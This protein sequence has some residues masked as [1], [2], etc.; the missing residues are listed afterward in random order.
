MNDL[1]VCFDEIKTCIDNKNYE[2][3]DELLTLYRKRNSVY[4]DFVAILDG[5]IGAYFGDRKRQWKAIQKGLE[6]N[7]QN[8]E[9]YVML[10]NYYL[11][12]NLHQAY[13]CYENAFFYC[14]DQEDKMQIFALMQ[15]LADEYGI[16]V[17]KTAIVILSYNLL[18]YTKQ[19]IESI[20]KSTLES[21]REIIII[22]NAS[23]DGSVE[24]L[25]TQKDIKLVLNTENK[26]FPAGCNQGIKEAD[27]DSDIFL[28]NNDTILTPNALFWL[29]MGLYENEN[30]GATG[31]VS[32]YVAN[33]QQ[34]MKEWEN[35]Q[36][37]LDF[38]DKNN[39]PLKYPYEEKLFLIGFAY[40]IKRSVLN[41]VGLLDEIFSPGN[42]EDVDY[43]LRVLQAGY[44]NVLCRNSFILHFG[45]KSFGKL[46]KGYAE[47]LN[48][49]QALLNKKWEM[50]MQY[51]MFPRMELVNLI[52]EE[53]EKRM[54]IL[55]IGCGCGAIMAKVKSQYPLSEIKGIEIVSKAAQLASAIGEVTCGDVEQ[56]DFSY[57][58]SYFDYCIM[59]DV[60]EHLREPQKVLIRLQKHMKKGGKII[61]SMPNMKH[62]SVMLP[63]L[64]QDAF[65]Y[66]N[67][68]IL[69]KT[70][71]KMYTN[72]EIQ[73]LISTSGYK[74]E[75][76]LYTTV[77]QPNEKEYEMINSLAQYMETP[78]VSTFMAYQYIVV[79]HL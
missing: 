20:R 22:D 12:M 33:G 10:G 76:V 41:K 69:D 14:D 79:A 57:P 6:H 47:I 42:S 29:R 17:P 75:K 45:S 7:S 21:S 55:D 48:K 68:G 8:Y 64:K 24:W 26:G 78:D 19:C 59:G 27:S 30:V 49:N 62:W 23:S 35:V 37:I 39:V 70:H 66:A 4:N 34:I 71:L 5:S 53:Q 25:K 1:L 65:T 32:N 15:Q 38:S 73:K 43:G 11:E 16:M 56:L 50:D 67:A 51:Y 28:L 61:V 9:L 74:I 60:L 36:E 44:K 77:G 72:H 13:I 2:K 3:A 18:D 58:E 52:E 46:G 63:L 40:L 54:N 31:S